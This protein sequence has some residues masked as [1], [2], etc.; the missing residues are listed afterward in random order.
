MTQLNITNGFY[1]HESL[2]ISNQD[3]VNWYPITNEKSA[4]SEESL[5]GTPGIE[6]LTTTGTTNEY[7]RGCWEK[8]GIGYF[9][10]GNVLYSLDYTI[11]GA[12]NETFA[13]TALGT[14]E[15]TERVFMADNG[16]QLMVLVPGGKAY[17]YNEQDG[18]PFQEITDADFRANGDPQSLLFIDG[19]FVCTTDE[20][21]WIISNLN[22]GT[23]WDALDFASAEADPDS[24]V[25]IALCKNQP[26]ILGSRTTEGFTNI[27]GS[28]FPFQRNNVFFAKGIVGPYAVTNAN[29]TFFI[30][31][32]GEKESPAFWMFTES[33][34]QKIS[35]CVIDTILSGYTAAELLNAFCWSIAQRGAY[36]VGLTLPD[37]TF[38]I[39]LIDMKWH[40]R[41]SHVGVSDVK[42]RVSSIM[43]VYGK[44][45]VGDLYTG[46]IGKLAA[47]IYKEY[48]ENIR[49]IVSTMP[50]TNNLEPIAVPKIELTMET[51]ISNDDCNVPIISLSMSKD[52]KVFNYER[53]R[54]LGMIGE[55]KKRLIWRRNG[56]F[57]RF[58]VLRFAFSDPVKP[59]LIRLDAE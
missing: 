50:F 30:I 24:I 59:V 58:G 34:Y 44:L 42:W 10:N 25:G 6:L 48:T 3:C 43:Q 22:D 19:Y 36:F 9:V 16:T 46:N 17:I 15:G 20:K 33:G 47:D 41:R 55:Y 29:D 28:G 52:G 45:I 14:I 53:L 35:T 13:Y 39:N 32:K 21:K 7:N 54:S 4:L 56:R 37:R 51:G 31:G 2:P 11:D 27:G 57:S 38:V 49:R 12:G 8:G 1:V 26:Y 5:L 18:T 23:T 40:E